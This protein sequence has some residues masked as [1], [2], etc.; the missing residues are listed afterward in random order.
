MWTNL[1]FCAFVNLPLRMSPVPL[2]SQPTSALRRRSQVLS[3]SQLPMLLIIHVLNRRVLTTAVI[4]SST[5]LLSFFWPRPLLFSCVNYFGKRDSFSR[6]FDTVL[7]MLLVNYRSNFSLFPFPHFGLW[8]EARTIQNAVLFQI[9][10]WSDE[11][12]S[13]SYYYLRVNCDVTFDTYKHCDIYFMQCNFRYHWIVNFRATSL[14]LFT[15]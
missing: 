15:C 2:R 9:V 8:F 6:I 4:T 11:T 7:C 3:R 14:L 12:K 10:N 1:R 5:R 13:L